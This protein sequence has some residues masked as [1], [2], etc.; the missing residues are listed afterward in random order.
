MHIFFMKGHSAGE[1][2]VAY[3]DGCLTIEE[4]MQVSY[5]RGKAGQ[6]TNTISG[7]MAAI[8]LNHLKVSSLLPNDVD[9]ACHNSVDSTT[10]SGPVESVRAFVKKMNNENIFAREVECSGVPLHSRYIKDMGRRFKSKLDDVIKRPR[11]RSSKWLSTCF[12][13][14]EWNTDDAKLCSGK[15]HAT[16]L[17][18]PVLFEEALEM[19]PENSLTIEVGPHALLKSLLKRSMKNATHISITQRENKDGALFLMNGLGT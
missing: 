6:E 14:D 11:A 13:K 7:A 5:C 1:I 4:A 19:L 18:N 17:L 12:A 2:G 9:I 16:N 8:G 3:A 15:Y 10:V